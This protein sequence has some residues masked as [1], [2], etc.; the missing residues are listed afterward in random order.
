MRLG[1][2]NKWPG[3]A[4]DPAFRLPASPT[5][6]CSR[7]RSATNASVLAEG[8]GHIYVR[9]SCRPMRSLSGE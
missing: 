3:Q 7:A 1:V 4:A 6:S 8:Q 9:H 5:P 2:A